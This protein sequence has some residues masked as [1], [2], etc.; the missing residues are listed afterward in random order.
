MPLHSLEV[1]SNYKLILYVFPL[2]DVIYV[3]VIKDGINSVFN[4][5]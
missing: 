5:L 2:G 4:E 1:V 3:S